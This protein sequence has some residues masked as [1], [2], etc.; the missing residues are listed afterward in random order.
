MK[1]SGLTINEASSRANTVRLYPAAHK[2][3]ARRNQQNGVCM[4]IPS[5]MTDKGDTSRLHNVFSQG[6]SNRS[7]SY[8]LAHQHC[9]ASGPVM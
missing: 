7:I 3:H 6:L 5:G 8:R 2:L 9:F 4:N 1:I